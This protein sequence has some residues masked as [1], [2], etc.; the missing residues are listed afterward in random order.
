MTTSVPVSVRQCSA[1]LRTITSHLLD[2]PIHFGMQVFRRLP[3]SASK[4][5][6]D[7]LSRISDSP[8]GGA[9]AAWLSGDM[10]LASSYVRSRP[11]HGWQAR[12]LGEL[13]L[14]MGDR[15][16]AQRR[17]DSLG[18]STGGKRLRS[19][20]LW[21]EGRMS[22]AVRMAPRSALRSRL[23]SETQIFQPSWKPSVRSERAMSKGRRGPRASVA[24]ALT[25]SLPH[26]QSGYTLRSHAVL[27]SV[28]DAGVPVVVTT[29]PGYPTAVG[30][31]VTRGSARVDG[32][33]YRFDLP[34]A[35]GRTP[36]ARL[37]QQAGFLRQ[38]VTESGAGVIH[39]TTHFT[40]GLV[41][42][43]VAEDLGIPWV[44]EVRGSLE[45]T[46]AAARGSAEDR[47]AARNSERFQLFR[48]RETE[49]ACGADAVVTLGNTMSAEL[50]RRGVAKD[51]ILVAPNSVG[52]DVLVADWQ[53]EPG[54]VRK[55]LGLSPDG[56]WVGTAASLVAYEGL[57]VLVDAVRAARQ[58]GSD[59]RLLIVGD[60]VELPALKERAED[61]GDHAVFTGRVPPSLARTLVR[62]LDVF[63][64]PRKDVPVCRTI[65]P[66]KPTEAGGL[67]R[68]VIMSDLPALAEAL[69]ADARCIVP[70][71]SAE[72]LARM[73]VELAAAPDERR[74]MGEAA[75]R[76]V[77]EYR[78]WR[79]VGQNYRLMYEKLGVGR[80]GMPHDY[81]A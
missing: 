77:E 55:Q 50:Q 43:A 73:L 32:I 44:Y 78:T 59:V 67:G 66:L 65:T 41:A 5:V 60:G 7:V 1:L 14:S 37:E 76:W 63:V 51:K 48:A 57:D 64:V 69:P 42:R 56:V 47:D 39:T 34:V 3:P 28:R 13:A 10:K 21:H 46:W 71:E 27:T 33:D 81:D 49:V 31:F 6:G 12:V 29:R 9:S 8:V 61:L 2:D 54:D 80:G 22:D 53:E 23:E 25:N 52:D 30:K 36:A 62:A 20:I 4:Q 17:A 70:P 38:T 35:L 58:S 75:R 79:T 68:P 72:A 26:T 74:R 24:Y 45:D 15:P 40:N 19:R 11:A 16:A 18:D